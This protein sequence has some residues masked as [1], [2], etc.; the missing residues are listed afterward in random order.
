VEATATL[1]TQNTCHVTLKNNFSNGCTKSSL[2]TKPQKKSAKKTPSLLSD[3]DLAHANGNP[4]V[5]PLLV[6]TNKQTLEEITT[7]VEDIPETRA[8]IREVTGMNHRETTE[9][10]V[11]LNEATNATEVVTIT[12]TEGEAKG[13]AKIIEEM[14]VTVGM[15]DPVTAMRVERETIN[16]KV[17]VE[18]STVGSMRN[19]LHQKTF[20]KRSQE[21]WA[22]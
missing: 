16:L 15:V 13:D 5:H 6:I 11:S 14:T 4:S 19:H 7:T 20:T 12:M 17:V 21:R 9:V 3:P 22:E 18:E 1:C 8:I 2:I 10:T